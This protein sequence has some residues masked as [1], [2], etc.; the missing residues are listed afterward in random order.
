M[1]KILFSL[2]FFATLCVQGKEKYNDTIQTKLQGIGCQIIPSIDQI[3][4]NIK[5]LNTLSENDSTNFFIFKHLA[6]QYYYWFAKEKDS[7]VKEN[8]RK[9]SIANIIKVLHSDKNKKDNKLWAINNL[10]VLYEFGKNCNE[11]KYYYNL[12]NKKEKIIVNESSQVE[13]FF[14][15]NCS[16]NMQ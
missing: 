12:I 5:R 16:N 1:N 9:Q 6:K 7:V 8:Y 13:D 3:K 4:S 15:K 2:F 10:L 11:T 14:K